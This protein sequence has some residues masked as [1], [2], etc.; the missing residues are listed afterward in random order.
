MFKPKAILIGTLI[1]IVLVF[2]F[3][4][5]LGPLGGFLGLFLGGLVSLYLMEVDYKDGIIHGA[6]M[7]VLTGVVFDIL[8]ILVASLNGIS[9]GLY[10]AGGGILT[11]LVALIV[12]AVL[13]GIGAA[14]GIYLRGMLKNHSKIGLRG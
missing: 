13:T 4:L 3:E 12:Y 8:I 2:I 9:L 6:I 7:G 1:T 10:L 14:T 11:L 5:I